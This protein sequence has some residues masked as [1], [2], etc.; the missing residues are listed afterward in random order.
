MRSQFAYRTSSQS[1]ETCP[2]LSGKS[3][4]SDWFQKALGDLLRDH[5]TGLPF[6][7]PHTLPLPLPPLLSPAFFALSPQESLF[8]GYTGTCTVNSL[9]SDLPC[10]TKKWSLTGGGHLQKKINN[11]FQISSKLNWLVIQSCCLNEIINNHS[12]VNWDIFCWPAGDHCAHPHLS[13]FHIDLPWLVVSFVRVALPLFASCLSPPG[14]L[15]QGCHILV[16]KLV[17]LLLE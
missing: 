7:F 4:S 11:W 16:L 9:V 3:F 8:T 13:H 12:F 10:C 6:L 5:I 17:P 15:L 2:V 1:K 14:H